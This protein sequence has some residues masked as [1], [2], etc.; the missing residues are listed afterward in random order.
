MFVLVVCF[1]VNVLDK[2]LV[3]YYYYRVNRL[4]EKLL[5]GVRLYRK[6]IVGI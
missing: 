1:F 3:F 2:C 4:L 5:S 6:A